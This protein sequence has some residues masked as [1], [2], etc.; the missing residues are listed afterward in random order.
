MTL[1]YN[2]EVSEKEGKECALRYGTPYFETSAASGSGVEGAFSALI[3]KVRQAVC[4]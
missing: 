3:D 2:P 1:L 4:V